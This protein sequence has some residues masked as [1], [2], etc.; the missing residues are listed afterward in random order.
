MKKLTTFILALLM[1]TFAFGQ[2]KGTHDIGIGIGIFTTN[3]F[4]DATS[5]IIE[6]GI[7]I[8]TI[9]YK[10]A[11]SLPALY[12]NYKI[13]AKNKWFFYADGVY[14][15]I[16]EDVYVDD[17]KVGDLKHTYLTFGFGTDY[18]YVSKDW[19][20]IYSGASIAY[21]AQY[22]NFTGSSP[23]FED[24]NDGYFN[25][26]VNALGFRFGKALAATLEIGVGYKGIANLGVSYQF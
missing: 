4:L 26:H 14:Q 22:S 3:D 20:Q 15:S 21:T 12:L 24:G 8:G 23:G 25:F 16:S 7:S 2:E 10:N 5:S 6:S 17:I 11:T 19:L 13:A 18:H 1:S 9:T